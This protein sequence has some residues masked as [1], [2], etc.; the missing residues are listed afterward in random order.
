MSDREVGIGTGNAS[1]PH[2]RRIASAMTNVRPNVTIRKACP[3]RPYRRR[4]M[5]ISNAAP[6]P[7]TRMGAAISATQKLPVRCTADQP[8]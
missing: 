6:K 7:P 3:S 5:P 4:R 2:S 8:T 1:T